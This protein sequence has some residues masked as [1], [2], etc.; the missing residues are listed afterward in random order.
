MRLKNI[1]F[2][3]MATILCTSVLTGCGTS[4]AKED[5]DNELYIITEDKSSI[6]LSNSKPGMFGVTEDGEIFMEKGYEGKVAYIDKKGKKSIGFKF[7]KGSEFSYGIA[8]VKEGNTY[9]IINQKGKTL[10]EKEDGVL[11]PLN[12]NLIRYEKLANE[13]LTNE[14]TTEAIE[15]LAQS[16]KTL[17]TTGILNTKGEVIVEPGRYDEIIKDIGEGY[18]LV[19]KNKMYG[20]LNAEGNEIIPCEYT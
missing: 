11:S 20:L 1:C 15:S 6:S 17:K 7:D 8:G 9:K 19:K 5:S 2:M 3:A 14:N 18:I 12:N 10:V 13:I 4:S 16:G